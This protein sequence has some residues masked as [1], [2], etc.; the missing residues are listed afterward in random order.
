MRRAPPTPPAPDAALAALRALAD[1]AHH[2]GLPRY[3]IPNARAIGVRMADIQ[4]LAKSFGRHQPL[5]EALW[6][7]EIYEAR[8]L[9]A[10]VAEPGA[11]PPATLERWLLDLD[12]WAI[13]DTLCFHLLDRA[14]E[15]WDHVVA[16]AHRPE[17]LVRR[18][19]FA[20]LAALALHDK[21]SPD[22]RFVATFPLIQAAADDPRDLVKKGVSWALRS[23]GHRSPGLHAE[24]LALAQTLQTSASAPARWIGRDTLRDLSRPAVLALATRKAAKK[25]PKRPA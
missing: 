21:S 17:E 23:V 2:A 20:L 18:A 25:A 22:A 15:A 19:A 4:A 10:F 5:A 11:L 24:A 16:W 3:G 14:P 6:D 1:P 13:C 12:S 8:L 7:S 9:A